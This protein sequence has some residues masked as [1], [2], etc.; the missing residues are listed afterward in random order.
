MRLP[1][2]EKSIPAALGLVIVGY[3]LPWLSGSGAAL[4]F[5]AYDLA[6]WTALMPASSAETP[7]LLTPFLLRLPLL[8]LG[9][10]SAVFSLD[11]RGWAR[12]ALVGI[13]LALA[14]ANL[15]PFEFPAHPNNLNYRQQAALAGLTLAAGLAVMLLSAARAVRAVWLGAVMAAAGAAAALVGLARGHALLS[16]YGLAIRGG[17]GGIICAAGFIW[18]ALICIR[19]A[20]RAG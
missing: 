11:R 16:D 2:I 18:C 3:S 13:W 20:P 8:C 14:G 4:S 19:R 5:H 1:E 6:E 9:A 15:P 10:I 17:V 7:P 12:A